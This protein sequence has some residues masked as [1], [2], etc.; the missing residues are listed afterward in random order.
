MLVSAPELV[1]RERD[2]RLWGWLGGGAGRP[3]S[4]LPRRGGVPGEICGPA[5]IPPARPRPRAAG[6]D[7]TASS[8]RGGLAARGAVVRGDPPTAIRSGPAPGPEHR[9]DPPRR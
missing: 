1:K 2:L 4:R 9:A 7:S 5:A 3:G 8:R 6:L